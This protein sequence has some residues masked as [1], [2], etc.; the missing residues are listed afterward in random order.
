MAVA[1]P[2]TVRERVST[3][4]VQCDSAPRS[5]DHARS[6][7]AV[8][9]TVANVA[10]TGAG[11]PLIAS[12]R[13]RSH[14]ENHSKSNSTS[15]RSS[16][17]HSS[18]ASSPSYPR[19]AGNAGGSVT[20]RSGDGASTSSAAAVG[21]KCDRFT[22]VPRSSMSARRGNDGTSP[23]ASTPRDRGEDGKGATLLRTAGMRHRGWVAASSRR[24]VAVSVARLGCSSPRCSRRPNAGRHTMRE[25]RVRTPAPDSSPHHSGTSVAPAW[26][27]GVLW[28]RNCG[29]S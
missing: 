5:T 28:N 10:V 9:A 1:E 16:G 20:I 22:N 29:S 18:R 6:A 21:Q 23:A 25:R 17:G 3:S 2:R 19:A 26:N 11:E 7:S 15:G 14:C 8:A 12:T 13:K 4:V 27:G 24:P